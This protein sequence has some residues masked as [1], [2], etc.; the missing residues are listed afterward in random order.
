M[1]FES[2]PIIVL[3]ASLIVGVCVCI[4]AFI[5]FLKTPVDERMPETKPVPLVWKII[6][7]LGSLLIGLWKVLN[8]APNIVGMITG[9]IWLMVTVIIILSIVKD[10]R[11]K[12][13]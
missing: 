11:N 3:T 7:I 13:T 12:K 2:W 5:K 1:N 6:A 10:V 4:L 9:I 8:A